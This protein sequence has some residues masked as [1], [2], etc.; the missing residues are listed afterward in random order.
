MEMME[1]QALWNQTTWHRDT[2]LEVW[3]LLFNCTVLTLVLGLPGNLW[4]CWVVSRTKS[5]QTCNNA[6]LVSLASSDLLK[7]SVDTPLLLFSLLRSGGGG[8][9]V[10]VV[11]CSLQQFTW[12]LCS[13]VQLLTLVGISVDRFQAIAFPSRTEGR[14][15]RVRV[16]ILFI[17][18][19][20]LVLALVSLTL[21]EKALCYMLCRPHGA[22]ETLRSSDPF[23]PYVLVPVWG[24]CITLIVIHYVRIFQVVRQ[25][26][27]Q[28]FHRGVQLPPTV[29]EEVWAWLSVPGTGGPAPGGPFIPAPGGPF[30]PLPPR[31]TVLLVAEAP[32]AAPG[33]GPPPGRRPEIVGAVCLMTPGA[34][35]RGKKRMEG[36]VAQRFGYIIIA[37]TLFWMPMVVILLVKVTSRLDTDRL[38]MELETSAVVLTCMQAAVD[39]LIYTLVT[40]QFRSELSKILSSI[41]GCPLKPRA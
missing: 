34:K 13:C 25:H 30:S 4:V 3:F 2:R 28:V 23:G 22:G 24:L 14:K 38:L 31:R 11:V 40:R 33:T 5:L 41:P 19:S 37:F 36:K 20:G 17:W 35:E 39:P 8:P 15:V 16:W 27:K 1:V 32:C 12:A 18:A 21:S 10:P 7:C 6:L 9:R 26:R 29:S